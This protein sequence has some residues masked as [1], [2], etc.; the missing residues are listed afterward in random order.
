[1]VGAMTDRVRPVAAL[2]RPA[3]RGFCRCEVRRVCPEPG[4][5]QLGRRVSVGR[6]PAGVSVSPQTS[7]LVHPRHAVP[8]PASLVVASA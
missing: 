7:R 4:S 8:A 3:K 6:Q 2:L 1:L 5:V